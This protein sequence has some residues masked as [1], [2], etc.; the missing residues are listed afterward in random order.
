MSN[1]KVS[2]SVSLDGFSAGPN[3]SL[4]SPLGDGGERL[5]EWVLPLEAFRRAHGGEGGDV[6][7]STPVVESMSDAGAC[8][9]GRSMF[10]G[11]TGPWDE[12]WRG[13]WGDEPPFNA[14]VF[15]LTHHARDP[16]PMEGGTTFYFV[17]E[18]IEGAVSRAR[19]AAGNRDVL[20]SGGASVVQQALAAGL[21]DEL[22]LSIAPVLLGG[23]TRFFA[24]GASADL[25]QIAAI[26]APGVVH[27]RYRVRR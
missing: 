9:M 3:Q 24:E 26:E 6:N 7:E 14:P 18:G 15:V 5:H 25:E 10:G 27:L 13:W 23:G 16:L 19:D 21:V 20:I 2:M 17:T 11:G 8:V 22:T 1:V 12:S 4:E